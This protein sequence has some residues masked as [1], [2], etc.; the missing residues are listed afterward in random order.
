MAEN[1]DDIEKRLRAQAKLGEDLRKSSAA[2][3]G[4][5]KDYLEL[6]YRLNRARKE[7][8]KLEEKIKKLRED[9]GGL[10]TEEIKQHEQLLKKLKKEND[11]LDKGAKI[12]KSQ[13]FSIKNMSVAVSRDLLKGLKAVS[14]EVKTISLG[15]FEQDKSIRRISVNL[16]VVGKRQDQFL[17]TVYRTSVVTQQWGVNASELA[18]MYSSYVDSIGRLLPL[19]EQNATAL[20]LMSKGTALGAEGAAEMA[21]NMEVFGYSIEKTAKY[22]EDV[23]NMSESMGVNSS[24]TLKILN[25]NL[26]KAQGFRFKDGQAGMAKMAALSAKLRMDMSEVLGFAEKLWDPEGSIEAAASL[27][28]MGGAFAQMADPLQLLYK[29]RNNPQQLLEDLSKAAASTVQNMGK[30]VYEIPAMELQR[31]K[32]VADATG[33]SFDE[34][35]QSAKTVRRQSDISSMMSPKISQDDREYVATL[36]EWSEEKGGF[37]VSLD[38]K[39]KTLVKNLSPAMIGK[40]KAEAKSLEERSNMAQSFDERLKNIVLTF[41][42][43]LLPFLNGLDRG[44]RPLFEKM[45]GKGGFTQNMKSLADKMDTW[46]TKFGFWLSDS[47]PKFIQTMKDIGKFFSDIF[48]GGK[49]GKGGMFGNMT[50]LKTASINIV[51]A[52]KKVGNFLGPEGSLAALLLVAFPKTFK[53]AFSFGVD[54]L[55]SVFNTVYEHFFARG[56]SP[57]N[58]LFVADVAG[59]GGSGGITDMMGNLTGGKPTKGRRNLIKMFG[60]NKFSK[61]LQGIGNK[62]KGGFGLGRGMIGLAKGAGLGLIGEGVSLGADYW[63]NNLD[64]RNSTGGKLLGIGGQAAQYAGMGA[65]FGPWGALIGGLVG[66]G[67]GVYDEYFSDEAK[68]IAKAKPLGKRGVGGAKPISMMDGTSTPDGHVITT[69]KGEVYKT[70][71][72]DYIMVGQPTGN[73]GGG[74][75]NEITINGTL[76]LKGDGFEK[77]LLKDPMFMNELTR[78]ITFLMRD[79]SR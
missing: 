40:L 39:T 32:Q 68:A 24:K 78:T 55:K 45:L 61:G 67:K 3:A 27:Q 59:G 54:I 79:Q 73:N 47:I 18:S 74:M 41:K 15:Y 37:T 63:R 14:R 1:F 60:N 57:G 38:G 11:E 35:V 48:G 58:P 12:L 72:K 5:M 71:M 19:T 36:A 43:L 66:A 69:P 29:G 25:Q 28:M 20:A 10:V 56:S 52:I 31:L 34:L 64:D 46:G 17:K 44:L 13:A 49:D 21:S 76:M 4:S 6:Q 77:D 2:M 50:E 23:S 22:V 75:S 7:E 9:S 8:A 70:H 53:E 51:E 62:V 16:G 65:M 42:A 33:V 30:G 26:K